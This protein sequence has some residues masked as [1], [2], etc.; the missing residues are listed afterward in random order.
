MSW[1]VTMDI[2]IKDLDALSEACQQNGLTLRDDLKI[3]KGNKY[4]GSL[5]PDG[6]EGDTSYQLITDSDFVGKGKS[7]NVNKLV[8]DYSEK[9]CYKRIG[10][11]GTILERIEDEN[12]V[13][14]R[15]CVNS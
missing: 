2:L 10:S 13:K 12:G 14:L 1:A 4:I 3:Y 5:K 15:V 6:G 7:T 8:M 11:I 9:V